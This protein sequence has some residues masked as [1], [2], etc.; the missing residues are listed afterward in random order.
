VAE[1][2]A[3]R[4]LQEIDRRGP[5]AGGPIVGLAPVEPGSDVGGVV[6]A[7]ARA[8]VARGGPVL[9]VDAGGLRGTAERALRQAGNVEVWTYSDLRASLGQ[10]GNGV[11]A[12]EE[13]REAWAYVLILMPPLTQTVAPDQMSWMVDATVLTLPWGRVA[14]E[15]VTAALSDQP[16]FA[17]A[18]VTTVLD[19]AD[20]RRARRMLDPGGYE[21]RV[22]HA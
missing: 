6:A 12:L 16:A 14:P 15:L 7:L 11:P 18:L 13:L 19:G 20:L 22:L 21:A 3:E 1:R 4:V 5:E 10:R 17:G 2:T 9:A 8:M